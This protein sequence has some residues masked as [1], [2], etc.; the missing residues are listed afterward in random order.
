MILYNPYTTTNATS[1]THAE[2]ILALKRIA[3][4]RGVEKQPHQCTKKNDEY[5]EAD[6]FEQRRKGP[7]LCVAST[8]DDEPHRLLKGDVENDNP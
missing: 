8:D 1:K 3:H 5:W 7:Q 4:L 6:S 2:A